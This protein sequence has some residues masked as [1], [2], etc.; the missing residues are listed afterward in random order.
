MSLI[1]KL[2]EET[3]K[4]I[5]RLLGI[6]IT[7]KDKDQF[8]TLPKPVEVNENGSVKIKNLTQYREE[9]KKS[10]TNLDFSE[11]DTTFEDIQH[12]DLENLD[13]KIN[14]RE[15]FVPYGGT[16]KFGNSI[17]SP[18]F[19]GYTGDYFLKIYESRLAGNT[20][21]GDLSCFEDKRTNRSVYVWYSEETFDDNYKSQYPQF[22]LSSDAP[23]NLKDKYYNPQ[24][25]TEMVLDPIAAMRDAEE[26]YK[27]STIF[28][29]QN[30][31]FE[32][33]IEYHEFLKGKYLGNFKI[34]KLDM[35]KINL[36]EKYGLEK[37]KSLFNNID[38]MI[39]DISKY[40][41]FESYSINQIDEKG[42][43]LSLRLK[44]TK[45]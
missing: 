19:S 38:K 23:N 15:V 16:C 45:E 29:R 31:T 26:K 12:L 36:I 37:A 24:I 6:N 41:N 9:L 14:L 18:M 39:D 32:E 17:I 25:L 2:K 20:V 40:E 13:L 4:N 27:P 8:N 3:I 1:K 44:H 28:R 7:N 11:L 33:Y 22:F 21:I 35:Q 5:E 10:N 30:L 34:K 43:N 42:I